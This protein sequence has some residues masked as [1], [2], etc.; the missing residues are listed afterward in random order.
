MAAESV[1]CP[2]RPAIRLHYGQ[3]KPLPTEMDRTVIFTLNEQ[4]LRQAN[5]LHR[6]VILRQ[7]R[8]I[9]GLLLSWLVFVAIFA[10]YHAVSGMNTSSLI[11]TT[12]VFAIAAIPAMAIAIAT[13]PL[14]ISWCNIRQ[15]F[16]HDK[17]ISRPASISWDKDAYEVEQPGIKN[18]ILWKD[19]MRL[20]ENAKLFVF[21]L[22]DYQYQ[23]LPKR[24]LSP[25]QIADLQQTIAAAR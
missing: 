7:K 25:E 1:T 13:I 21:F 10:G 4:D 20:S 22:S 5:G 8:T 12:A 3:A 18:H 6:W 19:Y 23:I 2:S 24:V 9:I 17:Q 16:R 15:R 11:I 14:A